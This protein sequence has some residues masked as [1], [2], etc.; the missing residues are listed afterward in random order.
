MSFFESIPVPP[1][2][3]P[4]QRHRPVWMPSDAVIPGSVPAEL[5][6]I[7]T[8]QVAVA[9]GSVRAYPNGFEFTLHTRLRREDESGPGHA[10]PLELHGYRRGTQ[11]PDEVMRL[12]VMYADGRRVAT[13]SGDRWPDEDG[14]SEQLVLQQNGGGG[15][16]RTWD[17]DMWVY[18]LPPEGPVTFVASWPKHGVTETRAE[19][20][21]AAIREAARRAVILW[22]EEPAFGP[23]T[24]RS[25]GTITA[26]LSDDPGASSE[27]DRDL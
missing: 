7:R 10:D 1:P 5:M 11:V 15:G 13:R 24:A 26:V 18:P 2:P 23:G 9:I 27:P 16:D 8:E 19:L 12:G 14:D 6:L 25:T 21:G 17:G 20:D 3:E 4:V 22:P